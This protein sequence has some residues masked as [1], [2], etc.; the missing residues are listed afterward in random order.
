MSG[1]TM[2]TIAFVSGRLVL[3]SLFLFAGILKVANYDATLA[4]MAAAG[5]SP[6]SLMLPLTVALELGG[7]LIL[8]IGRC[9]A[10]P[11]ACVLALFTLATNYFFHDFWNMEDQV[12]RLEGALFLKNV[13]IAGGLLFTAGALSRLR[14]T[15]D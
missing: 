14:A 5:L 7:G 4:D 9:G 1:S 11:I 10:A 8:A 12:T 6:V 13:A 2:A 3:A 15:D